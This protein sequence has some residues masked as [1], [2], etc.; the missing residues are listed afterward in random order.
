MQ[1]TLGRSKH[2]FET[3]NEIIIEVEEPESVARRKG[4]TCLM[5]SAYYASQKYLVAKGVPI[6]QQ[7]T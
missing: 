6:L 5:F 7:A 2:T 3:L 1:A 4:F